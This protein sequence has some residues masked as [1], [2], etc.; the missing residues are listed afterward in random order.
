MRVKVPE[1][2]LDPL[3]IMITG[4]PFYE[5]VPL[6]ADPWKYMQLMDIFL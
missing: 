3:T 4:P 6:A 2:L 1:D 5:P